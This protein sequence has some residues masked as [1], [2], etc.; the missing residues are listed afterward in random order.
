MTTTA[1]FHLQES[2]SF[3]LN[4]YEDFSVGHVIVSIT[5]VELQ[6]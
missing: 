5:V 6:V 4:N 3:K 1:K 2:I